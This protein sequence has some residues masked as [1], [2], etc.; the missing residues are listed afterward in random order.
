LCVGVVGEADWTIAVEDLATLDQVLRGATA[1]LRFLSLLVGTFAVSA[2]LVAAVGVYGTVS[3]NVARRRRELGIR[4]PLGATPAWLR[5]KV[6]SGG[7]RLACAGATVGVGGALLL[8]RILSE[9]LYQ[10]SPRDGLVFVAV[11][12]LLLSMVAPACWVPARRAGAVA[13]LEALMHEG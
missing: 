4:S 7:L 1:R 3:F 9:V 10:V 6:P 12:L 2:L 5:G 11:P 8:G 13:P